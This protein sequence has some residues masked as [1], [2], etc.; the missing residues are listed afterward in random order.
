MLKETRIAVIRLDERGLWTADLYFEGT[1]TA[2]IGGSYPKSRYCTLDA[3]RTW[4]SVPVY[5]TTL[6]STEAVEDWLR[7]RDI[8]V[9]DEIS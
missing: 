3:N 4:G 8:E 1:H 9:S 5:T 2:N 7:T 6:R